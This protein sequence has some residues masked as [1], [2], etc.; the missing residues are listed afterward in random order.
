MHPLRTRQVR[1]WP[2]A[3]R[4]TIYGAAAGEEVDRTR[5]SLWDGR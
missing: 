2:S 4:A 3:N 1:H 5:S